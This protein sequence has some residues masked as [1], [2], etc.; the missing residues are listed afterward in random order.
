MHLGFI[1]LKF[2]AGSASQHKQARGVAS[3]RNTQ[4]AVSTS[5]SKTAVSIC[6]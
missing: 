5:G 2:N 4:T 6:Y 1:A 3:W